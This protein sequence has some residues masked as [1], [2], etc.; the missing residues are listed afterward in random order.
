[1]RDF[2]QKETMTYNIS[3]S[4]ILLA[5]ILGAWAVFFFQIAFAFGGEGDAQ[6][7]GYI[8]NVPQ[9][10]FASLCFG[11]SAIFFW[12]SLTTLFNNKP[13]DDSTEGAS[14]SLSSSIG[15]TMAYG[16]LM[17][18]AGHWYALSMLGFTTALLLSAL[19]ASQLMRMIA[20]EQ[21]IVKQLA[22][23]PKPRLTNAHEIAA[24][25]SLYDRW[26]R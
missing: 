24:M 4:R 20:A 19:A 2:K 22:P 5:A 9:W 21:I 15:L 11:L 25:Q 3:V 7:F 13:A 16:V 10:V 23:T 8:S 18:S 14:L 17:P 12:A 1:M 6:A 26:P